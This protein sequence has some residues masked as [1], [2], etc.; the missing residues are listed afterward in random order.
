M[1]LKLKCLTRQIKLL[2]PFINIMAK[3]KC[4]N[5]ETKCGKG[6]INPEVLVKLENGFKRLSTSTSQSLLKRYLTQALFD[7]LKNKKTSFGST[8]L[9][10]IQSGNTLLILCPNFV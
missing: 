7:K 8:L 9:D 2:Y 4:H 5:C 1:K 6:K 3:A 10:C